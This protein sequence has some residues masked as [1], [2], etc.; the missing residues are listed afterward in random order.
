MSI[1]EKE[2]TPSKDEK[3]KNEMVAKMMV[4]RCREAAKMYGKKVDVILGGSYA[5]DTWLPGKGDIDLF[6]AFDKELGKSILATEGLKIAYQALSGYEVVKR[7]AE[8]PYLE[9]FVDGIRVNVVPCLKVKQGEWISAADRSPFHTEL[10]T[11]R[12][13]EKMRLH[14]R[15]LKKLLQTQRLYGAEIKIRGFSGYVC[16]VLIAKWGGLE[17]VINAASEWKN[18]TV[19]SLDDVKAETKIEG[20]AI[21]DPVDQRRNLA[22]AIAPWKISE[23]IFL[24]RIMMRGTSCDPFEKPLLNYL[25]ENKIS[26]MIDNVLV[27]TFRHKKELEDTIWGELGRS[28]LALVKHLKE[29]GF[30]IINYAFSSD[31]DN[32]AIAMLMPGDMHMDLTQKT[33]PEVFRASETDRF[34]FNDRNISWF[35]LDNFRSLR[36]EQRRLKNINDAIAYFMEKPVERVGFSRGIASDASKSW[37][38]MHGKTI[39]ECKDMVVKDAVRRVF[40]YSPKMDTC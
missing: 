15:L 34:L 35:F 10:M 7:F 13:D 24:S 30:E 12:L 27:V 9:G 36:I 23:F 8:H 25:D 33:G 19:V 18:D 11:K 4:E 21:L 16:E 31:L 5:H 26:S 3:R 32:S 20:F 17:E 1:H 14:V 37:K 28:S 2:V 38:I 39:A 29:E 40:G 22:K 6:L